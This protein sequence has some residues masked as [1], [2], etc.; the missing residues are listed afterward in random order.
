V[1]TDSPLAF[2]SVVAISRLEL[3]SLNQSTFHLENT[4]GGRALQ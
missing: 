1:K 2:F 4:I 3:V